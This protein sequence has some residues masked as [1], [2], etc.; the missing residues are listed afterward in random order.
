MCKRWCRLVTCPDVLRPGLAAVVQAPPH[1]ERVQ[2]L[3]RWL[4]RH[5]GSLRT[6]DISLGTPVKA[7][8]E[9]RAAQAELGRCLAVACGAGAVRRLVVRWLGKIQLKLGPELAA[10]GTCASVC[11]LLIDGGD[12]CASRACRL[13]M[14]HMAWHWHE[15]ASLGTL[16]HGMAWH[17]P[18]PPSPVAAAR[19]MRRRYVHVACPLGRLT[20]LQHC[21]LSGCIKWDGAASLPP[22][23]TSLVLRNVSTSSSAQMWRRELPQQVRRTALGSS[24]LPGWLGLR[25]VLRATLLLR[26]TARPGSELP[27]ER[28]A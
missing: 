25:H 12:G 19:L 3:R 5:A 26:R 28:Q 6:L 7:L 20:A 24:S 1:L 4:T 14:W 13:C 21:E 11:S 23:L 18:C 15:P 16:C 27:V 22:S 10:C 17:S 9:A 8:A 2:S